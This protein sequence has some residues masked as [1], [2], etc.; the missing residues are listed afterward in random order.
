MLSCCP[1]P[2]GSASTARK[3]FIFRRNAD[4][5]VTFRVGRYI[6]HIDASNMGSV[7]LYDRL[8]YAAITANLPLTEKTLMELWEEA[9]GL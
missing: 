1:T 3:S 5:T 9:K 2:R 7:E 6:E 8:Q 4:G